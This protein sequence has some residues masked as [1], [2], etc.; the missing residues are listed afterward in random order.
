MRV[1]TFGAAGVLVLAGV[2]SAV[3]IPGLTGQ[4]LTVVLISVG[5]GGA[6]L[7]IFLEV[8][9]SED[10]DRAAQQARAAQQRARA[11]EQQLRGQ[12]G[13]RSGTGRA[14]TGRARPWSPRWPRRP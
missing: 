3:L 10:R 14:G 2:V 4:L 12:R 11:A 5:L 13:T 8:G 1:L 9:L 7:L 6:V